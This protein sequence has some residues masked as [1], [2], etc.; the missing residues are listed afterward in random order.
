LAASTVMKGGTLLATQVANG[1]ATFSAYAVAE[2]DGSTDLI[3]VNKDPDNSFTASVTPMSS[4]TQ[5][6]AL[7]LTARSLS[8]TSGIT[9]GGASVLH[10]GSWSPTATP[11]PIADGAAIVTVPRGSA[12]VVHLR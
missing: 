12:Q 5:A 7:T 3:L 2:K 1:P 9:L 11:L 4:F 8:S 6:S 10:D